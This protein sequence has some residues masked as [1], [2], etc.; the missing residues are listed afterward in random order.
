ML[1]SEGNPG[2]ERA[3]LHAAGPPAVDRD[4]TPAVEVAESSASS[5]QA[6]PAEV[7]V[8]P[9]LRRGAGRARRRT[10]SWWCAALAL[11][12]L[13]TVV[14]V[15]LSSHRRHDPSL[16]AFD[17]GAHYSYVVALRSGHI[18]AW[19]D[20]LTVQD[21]KL[22]DCLQSV[23]QPPAR[24]GA[25]PPA[26]SR[27]A[28]EGFDY[29]AQ[30]PPLG[31]LP[32]VLTANPQASPVA[33]ITAA[34][35]GGIIWAATSAVLLLI[36]A[37]LEDF[38]LL[39][40][41]ALLATCLFDPVFT[42][43]AA[44]VNNDAAG[45]A[46]GAVALIAWSWSRRRPRTSLWLGIVAGAVIGLTKGLYVVVPLALVSAAIVEEGR[47]LLSIQG[48]REA[49]R[50]HLC[51]LSMLITAV[52]VFAAF[53]FV[54][55]R[56]ATVPSSTVL[57][58][59]LGFSHVATLQPSTVSESISTTVSLF[60]PYYPFDGVNVIWGV[61]VFGLLVG[62]WFLDMPKAVARRVRG[63]SLGIL[64]GVIALALG[65]TIL[66][67]LQGHYNFAGA[68]RYEIC[69]LPLIGYVIVRGC[70]RFGVAAVGI[71]LPVICAAIQ[72]ASGK[73]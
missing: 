35:H 38:S 22:D 1:G 15:A 62:F 30:Q 6:F 66:V 67:F 59:L 39:G 3:P 37:L 60:Q 32:Y 7:P 24:C 29:E 23:G 16:D 19:G 43:S 4:V 25:T 40:L 20:R 58:A 54:Q 41:G 2:G 28:A 69:L 5:D 51:A 65:W 44:T 50:R 72:L 49:C 17:E 71:G 31:Y 47:P 33:A 13:A 42:Y 61:C 64:V 57:H 56:R 73:Y 11:T 63:L 21:R 52:V 8:V 14:S 68:I 12:V 26:A 27:Y 55:G 18:P 45:I 48:L 70:R 10:T 34:R 9:V 53:V 36:L 46:A